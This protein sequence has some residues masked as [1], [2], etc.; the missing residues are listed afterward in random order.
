MDFIKFA[1]GFGALTCIMSVQKKSDDEY[2]E[3][4]IVAGNKAYV[5][6]VEHPVGG[7]E[8]NTT[9][10]VPNQLYTTY[11]PPD[12][13]FEE[14][15]FQAA[16]KKKVVHSYVHPERYA[17]WFNMT[18][19]PLM[20]DEGDLCYC[21]YTMELNPA[22][23]M[24]RMANVSVEA[25]AN[26]LNTCIKL[27]G[28]ENFN[29]AMNDVIKDIRKLCGAASC[30]ILLFD[31][32]NKKCVTLCED[33][34]EGST[35]LPMDAYLDENFY[36]LAQSWEATIAGSN[37]IIAKNKQGMGEIKK[38]NPKWYESLTNAKVESLV[39]FPLKA[40]G[41]IL[42]YIWACN[43]EAERAIRIK[44]TLEIT[45]FI[46]ASEIGNYLLLDRLKILS[47]M[48]L[49]TG[50]LNRN[51]MNNVVSELC[52][53]TR[54]K[55]K[56][57][58]VVFADLNG[59]KTVNDE[60]GHQAGDDLLKRAARTLR[61]VFSDDEIFRAGGDEFS[62]IV[63]DISE[64]E[65]AKKAEMIKTNSKDFEGVSFAV[66]YSQVSK[67]KD[68]RKALRKADEN[69]YEDKRLFYEAHPEK[70][71]GAHKDDFKMQVENKKG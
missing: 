64:E 17:F 1:E 16:V 70:R 18:F 21:A 46:L 36:D 53:G 42:G 59:L 9:K 26:V 19:L 37:C 58:G 48:D 33:K 25:S 14:A 3:L 71:R 35:L 24:D 32:I 29:V 6:S 31:T 61:T 5:D 34:A 11:I 4:R 66:G 52:A 41:E 67:A 57:A 13:N 2:G 43:F 22:A 51:E 15:C 49:L 56:S 44:E 39:L 12:L 63:T 27:R 10:F 68:I 54:A 8:M 28:A 62:V 47:S 45:S 60:E 50:V 69:M 55:G 23:D 65:L 7:L 30:I 38:R 40:R 20:C